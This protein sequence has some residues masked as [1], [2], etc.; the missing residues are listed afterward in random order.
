MH[1]KSVAYTD[2]EITKLLLFNNWVMWRE[3]CTLA[4]SGIYL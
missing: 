3:K 1:Q 4:N 2:P